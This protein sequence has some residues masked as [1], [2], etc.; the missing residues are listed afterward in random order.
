MRSTPAGL[1][2]DWDCEELHRRLGRSTRPRLSPEQLVEPKAHRSGRGGRP[3]LAEEPRRR[4]THGPRSSVRTCSDASSA[5]WCCPS[6]T[7]SGGSTSPRW[8][9]CAPG[10]ACGP[11][12]SAIRWSSTSARRTTCSPTWS[13]ASR[14]T[15]CATCST[16]RW[17]S[18]QSRPDPVVRLQGT[19]GAALKRQATANG[20]VGPQ[21]PVPVRQR[22][23]VQEVPRGRRVAAAPAIRLPPVTAVAPDRRASTVTADAGWRMRFARPL[24]CAPHGSGSPRRHHRPPHPPRTTPGG[25]FDVD[26]KAARP[27]GLREQAAAPDLWKDQTGPARSPARLARYEGIVG[28]VDRLAAATR[29]RRG[30]ASTWPT[31]RPTPAAAD[32]SVPSSTASTRTWPTLERETLFFGEYDDRAPP[33]SAST[34]GPAGWTPADWARDAAAHVPPVPGTPRLRRRGR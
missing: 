18:S 13:T 14:R 34:P 28:R 21:R 19:G 31:R 7:P 12:A 30:A 26:G 8:T 6:S 2:R 5:R 4:T 33:S 29:R 17:W 22:Q 10:S 11:W 20:K 15:R 25:S 3:L 9:T 16:P 1:P 27:P 32:E 24:T 23:E